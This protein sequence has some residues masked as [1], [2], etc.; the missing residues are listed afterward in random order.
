MKIEGHRDCSLTR[1]LPRRRGG[2]GVEG[3]HTVDSQ[4]LRL[5]LDEHVRVST[6][7]I[8]DSIKLFCCTVPLNTP[9][10]CSWDPFVSL[11]WESILN[12][13]TFMGLAES[14]YI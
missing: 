5:L 6:W 13:P 7:K 3:I 10:V 14:D 12:A 11:F 9:T 4:F 2:P 8:R 1:D